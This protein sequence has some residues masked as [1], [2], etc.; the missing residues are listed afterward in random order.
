MNM[1]RFLFSRK[2]RLNFTRDFSDRLEKEQRQEEAA[3]RN[4]L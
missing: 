1:I 3:Y 2:Y 4:S